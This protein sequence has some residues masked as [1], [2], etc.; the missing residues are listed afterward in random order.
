MKLIDFL[1]LLKEEG[2]TSCEQFHAVVLVNVEKL[3]LSHVYEV[4]KFIK[5]LRQEFRRYNL[6]YTT[7]E[8]E[9]ISNEF[10]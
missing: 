3:E 9:D 6:G 2:C 1:E 10:V 4:R 7:G 5:E 8:M